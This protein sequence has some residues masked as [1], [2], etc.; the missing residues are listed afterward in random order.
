MGSNRKFIHYASK[1]WLSRPVIIALG[2]FAWASG[3]C[4]AQDSITTEVKV[5]RD[6]E[7][8]IPTEYLTDIDKSTLDQHRTAYPYSIAWGPVTNQIVAVGHHTILIDPV[9]GKL[10][11]IDPGLKPSSGETYFNWS[12]SSPILA[13]TRR[14][15]TNI[16]DTSRIHDPVIAKIVMTAP[17]VLTTAGASVVK[18]E[19]GELLV[20]AGVGQKKQ[21][22]T[23]P[24]VIAYDL[25][26][27]IQKLTW[28][29]PDDGTN[30]FIGEAKSA[31]ADDQNIYVAAY[32]H[33]VVPKGVR[34]DMPPAEMDIWIINLSQGK[35]HCRLNIYDKDGQKIQ[36]SPSGLPVVAFNDLDFS[37]NGRW[38]IASHGQFTDAYDAKT[39]NRIARLIE[40]PKVFDMDSTTPGFGKP[41]FSQDSRWLLGYSSVPANIQLWRTSDWK[42]VYEAP[43]IYGPPVT[44]QL[45]TEF[46]S[47]SAA[48]FN[49]DGSALA[50]ATGNKI[51]LYRI[52]A[53]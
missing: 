53:R 36:R 18:Q 30:Y 29:F 27:G 49:V 21:N 20:L 45:F 32:T 43:F 52:E 47:P 37:P 25:K 12:K 16:L 23:N 2:C 1:R 48:D 6:K 33:R 50:V 13:M 8:T 15:D 51:V 40:R 26:T 11:R 39:C 42:K 10:A 35:L 14:F 3:T 17:H 9:S 38:V 19:K 7:I 41:K 31:I 24:D 44:S 28:R 4:A 34:D 22:I 5:Q 46:N